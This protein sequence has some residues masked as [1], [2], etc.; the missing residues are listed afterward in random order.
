LEKIPKN[1]ESRVKIYNWLINNITYELYANTFRV[2]Q[3][4]LD[5]KKGNC[6]NKALLELALIKNILNKKG[7]LVYCQ[8]KAGL[9]YTV[10]ID[11]EILEDGITAIYEVIAFD[12]IAE[13]IYYRQ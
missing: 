5:S 2:A 6:A 3:V 10:R 7:E 8:K 4:T 11:N 12:D 13:Y 9:H 1:I